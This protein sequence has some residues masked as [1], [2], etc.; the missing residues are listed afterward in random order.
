MDWTCGQASPHRLPRLIYC[1]NLKI[2]LVSR[3]YGCCNEHLTLGDHPGML[4]QLSKCGLESS[5][6]FVLWH[7][8][9][10]SLQVMEH[11]QQLISLQECESSLAENR[12][13]E[14]YFN[15]K[16]TEIVTCASKTVP[17]ILLK[18]DDSTVS[19]LK[20]SPSR[21]GIKGCFLYQFGQS[22]GTYAELSRSA[23]EN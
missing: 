4:N 12:L 5:I 18:I 3:V 20:Q 7:Q 17:T 22:K 11:I 15:K 2:L 10:F 16:M 21:N 8:S 9:G 23:F 6:P 19:T 14:Y 1:L 13:R